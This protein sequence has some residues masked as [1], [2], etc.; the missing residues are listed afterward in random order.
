MRSPLY[1]VQ[2]SALPLLTGLYGLNAFVNPAF[3]QTGY[4]QPASVLQWEAGVSPG[5]PWHALAASADGIKLVG[6]AGTQIFVSTNAGATWTLTGAPTNDWQAIAS[7]ADGSKFVAAAS[8]SLGGLNPPVFFGDG[9]IYLSS[10]AGAT[11]EPTFPAINTW[12]CVASSADGTRLVAAATITGATD[13]SLSLSGDGL[14][15]VSTNSGLTWEASAPTDNWRSVAASADGATLVT[16]A[17]GDVS[18]GPP[19][20]AGPGRICVSTNW[21]MTWVQTTA[22][23]NVG[24]VSVACSADGTR[25]VAADPSGGSDCPCPP[26]AGGIYVSTNSGQSWSAFGASNQV[27]TAVASSADG[28]KLVAAFESYCY[29][30]VGCCGSPQFEW[31]VCGAGIYVSTDGGATWTDAGAPSAFESDIAWSALACS[32]DGYRVVAADGGSAGLLCTLPYQGPWRFAD[33]SWGPKTVAS[34]SD[35]TKFVAAGDSIYTSRDSGATWTQTSATGGSVAS[36]AD[37]TRLIAAAAGGL[38]YQSTDSGATW[39]QTSAPGPFLWSS[40][41]SSADG[42]NLVAVCT[43]YGPNTYNPPGA[44]RIYHSSDSGANWKSSGPLGYWESVASSA[45]GTKLVASMRQDSSGSPGNIFQSTDSGASWHLSGAPATNWLSLASS[46][47][48][49]KLAA[50]TDVGFVY[51]STDSGA[52]WMVSWTPTGGLYSGYDYSVSLS[53]DGTKLVFVDNYGLIHISTDFGATWSSFDPPAFSPGY[54]WRSAT[55]SADGSNIV[56]LGDGIIGMLRA[57]APPP[58]PPPSPRLAIAPSNANQVLSWLV[59]SSSFVLQQSSD[60]TST[61]WVDVTN[62][63]ALNLTNLHSELTLRPPNGVAFYRLRRQ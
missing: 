9:L 47:D 51:V 28:T 60:L 41:A 19:G 46:A 63:P 18:L 6:V 54:G 17:G 21:G 45:D 50:T 32:A 44:G 4:G 31:F 30:L 48:G 26:S 1:W 43:L 23:T 13:G 62:Q 35:G 14:I 34:S 59:P 10:D 25:L 29:G 8:I 58:P 61:N 42:T 36:S 49:V 33:A 3:A 40:V 20:A 15:Y 56:A 7:S 37:G 57:P 12:S 52:T 16:A 5:Q 2:N 11:W 27:W 22:P 53:A 55:I 39:K 24:W 38:I